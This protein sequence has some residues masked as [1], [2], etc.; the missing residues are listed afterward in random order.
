MRDA[1]AE[2]YVDLAD[3][4]LADVVRHTLEQSLHVANVDVKTGSL[5][6]GTQCCDADPDLHYESPG[7]LFHQGKPTFSED[8][9]LPWEGT[10]LLKA[11][12]GAASKL[13]P[14][15]PVTLVV[16]VSE[17]P[18]EREKLTAQI[19]RVLARAG[20]RREQMRVEVL[21]AYKQGYSW[22]M[23][24][25]APAL[26]GKSVASLQIDFAKDVDLTG[27]RDMFSPARW[28]QELYPVDE[29]L[30]RKLNLPLA[31]IT[32]NEFD[33]HPGDPTYRVHALDAT[34]AEI[35]K[36]DFTVTAATQ[37]YNGVIP[38]Y[39]EVQVETGWVHLQS[40]SR[41]ILDQRIKT[42]TEEFWDHY[43][44]VTLPRIYHFVMA[45]AHGETRTEYQPLFD[46][47]RIDFRMSEPDYN[48]GLDHERISSLEASA[49]GHFL[50][51][52][53][54]FRDGGQSRKWP[55]I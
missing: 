37:A 7:F 6:A 49:G 34:G 14:G 40:G 3:P 16:R 45:Q 5:H 38:R 2:V 48:L 35:L 4:G 55:S 11:V 13:K 31:K 42:D 39:E 53:Q 21:C 43:Q 22:L 1:Q 25:I 9:V 20:V 19:V 17:S 10:R 47:L 30:A 24:E 50:F 51:D 15:E 46:T 32:F 12:Q 26:A 27:V 33:A 36:R 8:L 29:M 28:V 41:V 44:N 23:D 18:Q 54:F 52:R